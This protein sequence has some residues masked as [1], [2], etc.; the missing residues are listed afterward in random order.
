MFI[1]E[2]TTKSSNMF[3]VKKDMLVKYSIPHKFASIT[4]V[5]RCPVVSWGGGGVERGEVSWG[6]ELW[7]SGEL[8]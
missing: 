4:S 6:G 5:L 3:N 8:G 1:R 7:G 2:H